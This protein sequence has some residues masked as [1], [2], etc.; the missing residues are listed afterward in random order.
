MTDWTKLLFDW[1][2]ATV[3]DSHNLKDWEE[4]YHDCSSK[5]RLVITAGDSW[6]WGDTLPDRLNQVYGRLVS[7]SL[8][9]DWINIGSRGRS[10]SWIL[11]ALQYLA[12][13]VKG[14]YK[15]VIVIV[16]MTE[17][18][19]DVETGYMFPFDFH[20]LY[21]HVGDCPA[22]YDA[23]LDGAEQYWMQQL[24]DI[25]KSGCRIIVGHNFAW[26]NLNTMPGITILRDNWIEKLADYQN[27]DR[28]IKAKL[29]TGWIFNTIKTVHLMVPASQLVFKAWALPYIDLANQVNKWLDSSDLQS[30]ATSSKHPVP[31]GH[32]IWANYILTNVKN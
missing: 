27:K 30:K 6:T 32:E 7:K 26:H 15:E 8:D 25:Q 4:Y 10:N 5:D 21:E 14:H 22:F 24:Q 11:S 1:R 12:P 3:P 9:A 28:P 23:I 2:Q 16:T 18:G 20:Q 13:L 17:N 29:V 19:R 31:L